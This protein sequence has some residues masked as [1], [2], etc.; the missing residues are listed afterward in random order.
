D[1]DDGTAEGATP[2]E[3]DEG[4]GIRENPDEDAGDEGEPQYGGTI[5]VGLEAESNSWLPGE[6]TAANAGLSVMVAIYDPLVVRTKAGE[7]EP[8]LAES[9]EASED[10]GRY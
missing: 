1:D 9:V 4:E 3:S 10:F 5:T 2:E 7:I 6:S 8:Y